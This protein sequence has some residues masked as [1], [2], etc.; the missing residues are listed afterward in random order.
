M[1]ALIN[2]RATTFDLSHQDDND[3]S[4]AG[5]YPRHRCEW[6][7]ISEESKLNLIMQQNR[8]KQSPLA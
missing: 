3:E 7:T 4:D 2:C 6:L 1:I 5:E 8:E